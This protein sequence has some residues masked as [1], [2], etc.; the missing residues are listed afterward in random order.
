MPS[1]VPALHKPQILVVEDEFLIRE[2]I[3]DALEDCGFETIGVAAA[4]DALG[5]ALT[6]V[7]FDVLFTDIDLGGPMDG[8]E[9]AETLREMRPNLPVAYTSGG[10]VR[11]RSLMVAGAVFFP[12]P[13]GIDRV[14]AHVEE[15]CRMAMNA[16]FSVVPQASACSAPAPVPA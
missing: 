12:K 10:I 14:C 3:C 5:L 4:E 13:Y 9:L 7:P 8:W 15:M 11:D 6:N 16:D 1:I 2:M